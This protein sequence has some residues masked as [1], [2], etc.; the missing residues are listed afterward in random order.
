MIEKKEK[1]KKI[2]KTKSE[3]DHFPSMDKNR[4]HN[5]LNIKKE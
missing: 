3:H 2:H 5:K 4:K 1:K